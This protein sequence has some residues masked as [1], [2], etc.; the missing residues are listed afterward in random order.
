MI[1]AFGLV[2]WVVTSLL[3]L[4]VACFLMSLVFW[5]YPSQLTHSFMWYWYIQWTNMLAWWV[6]RLLPQLETKHQDLIPQN[7]PYIIVANH[8][9]WLDILVLYATVF[10][11]RQAFVFVMKRSL[12]K[13]P[14]IGI[15]C[16]GLG[17][18]LL[19]RGGAR[20]K[21]LA[22]LKAA[23]K[24]MVTYR[25]GMMIFP[26]GTRYT[27]VDKKPKSYQKLLTPRTVGF[28]VLMKEL[29]PTVPVLDVT[30]VYSDHEHSIMDFLAGKFGHVSVVSQL[31]HVESRDAE[32]WLLEQWVKKD[33][34]IQSVLSSEKETDSRS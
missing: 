33:Q 24:K 25:H 22:L 20:R 28:E 34:L 4:G 17:H 27:K 30:L 18:P 8:Y 31:H 2:I 7:T 10:N 26:E 23:A 12:I 9:S 6:R 15:I 3:T 32:S 11:A 16:W 5:V 13:L 19:Y 21:N 14:M 29:G 1:Y